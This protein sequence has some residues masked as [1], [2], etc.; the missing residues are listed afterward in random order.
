MDLLK[1]FTSYGWS[2]DDLV[3][4]VDLLMVHG[5]YVKFMK[6]SWKQTLECILVVLNGFKSDSSKKLYISKKGKQVI[7]K[8]QIFNKYDD[9]INIIKIIKT[10]QNQVKWWSKHI[11]MV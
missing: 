4:D 1:T 11:K 3:L 10:W 8:R 5:V 2:L 6:R 9:K 7:L